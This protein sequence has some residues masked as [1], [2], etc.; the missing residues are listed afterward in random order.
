[1]LQSKNIETVKS[2]LFLAKNQ[3]RNLLTRD[4]EKRMG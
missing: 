4:G 1:M 3:L 2:R